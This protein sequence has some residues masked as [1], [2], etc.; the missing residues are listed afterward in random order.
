MYFSI[1]LFFANLLKKYPD[2]TKEIKAD[3][4]WKEIEHMLDS[5]HCTPAF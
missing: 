3:A 1:M 2:K 5:D 4:K